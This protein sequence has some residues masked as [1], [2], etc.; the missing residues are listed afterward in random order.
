MVRLLT[1]VGSAGVAGLIVK[2][3]TIHDDFQSSTPPALIFTELDGV[4][5]P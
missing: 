1:E 5:A 2:D 4:L 3:L